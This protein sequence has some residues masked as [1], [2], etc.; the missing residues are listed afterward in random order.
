MPNHYGHHCRRLYACLTPI[1]LC[2]CRANSKRQ[3]TR[4]ELVALNFPI[5]GISLANGTSGKHS[6]YFHTIKTSKDLIRFLVC[7]LS[8]AIRFLSLIKS[9]FL[10]FPP[11][12]IIPF[13][14]NRKVTR[15]P[16]CYNSQHW[17]CVTS[18]CSW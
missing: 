2:P 12:N 9:V 3:L 13:Q 15:G 8:F 17:S 1:R 14:M 7:M 4:N 16:I 6:R 10:W 5:L 18:P 11:Q